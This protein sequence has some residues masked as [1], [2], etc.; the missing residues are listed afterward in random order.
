[1]EPRIKN[2]K[3]NKDFTF[4]CLF[5]NGELKNF[6]IKPFLNKG[7]FAELNNF[8]KLKNF[9]IIDGVLNWFDELDISPDTVYLLSRKTEE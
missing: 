5:V 2:A 1:M 6:D 7:R 3:L 9:K 8:D 4:D